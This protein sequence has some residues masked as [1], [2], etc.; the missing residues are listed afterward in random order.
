MLADLNLIPFFIQFIHDQPF[1]LL[2]L[3]I[4]DA[5]LVQIDRCHVLLRLEP[6]LFSLAVRQLSLM[7]DLSLL[8]LLLCQHTLRYLLFFELVTQFEGL[9]FLFRF[10]F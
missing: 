2:L 7:L 4:G 9:L 8:D 5:L 10:L 6:G 1:P 3:K